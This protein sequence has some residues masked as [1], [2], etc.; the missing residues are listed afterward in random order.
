MILLLVILYEIIILTA[1]ALAIH[2]WKKHKSFLNPMMWWD[3]IA[4]FWF[5][6]MICNLIKEIS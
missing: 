4:L 6:Y 1:M 2:E 5:I 3:I